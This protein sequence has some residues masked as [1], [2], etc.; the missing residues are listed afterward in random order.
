[1][2]SKMALQVIGAG[3]PRTATLSQ[4]LALEKLGLEPCYHMVQVWSALDVTEGW[5]RAFQGNADWD[6]CLGGYQASVDWPGGFFYKELMKVYPQ[7]KVLLSVRDGD[8]WARSMRETI[9]DVLYGDSMMADLSSAMQDRPRLVPLHR[10]N[11]SN[12][13]EDGFARSREL[14]R[15]TCLAGHAAL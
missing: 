2:G 12:V 6:E 1:M 3:L 9:W 10:T 15:G 4:K 11:E 7:A 8:A 13:E 14:R 5:A